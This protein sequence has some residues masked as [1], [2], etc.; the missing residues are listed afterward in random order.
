MR[1]FV[2]GV[3]MGVAVDACETVAEVEWG[4]DLWFTSCESA[5]AGHIPFRYDEDGPCQYHDGNID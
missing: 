4:E 3:K 2:A 5:A 1:T